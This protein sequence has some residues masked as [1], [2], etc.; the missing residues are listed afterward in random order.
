MK[1]EEKKYTEALE[2]A[3]IKYQKKIEANN[4][5]AEAWDFYGAFIA[6]AIWRDKR[7]AKEQNA[8]INKA[9]KWLRKN[10]HKYIGGRDYLF[11]K[12]IMIEAFKY[13]MKGEDT[14]NNDVIKIDYDELIKKA[15]K[16]V[17]NREQI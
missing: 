9:C 1:N 8:L 11:L 10:A 15:I 4:P 6:G 5:Q 7:I 13:A 17:I 3:A 14:S 2:K 16:E 12:G